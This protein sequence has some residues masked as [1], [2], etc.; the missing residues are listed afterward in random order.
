MK[1][2]VIQKKRIGDVL[3][4]TLLLEALREKFPKAELH[5]LIYPESV[6]VVKNNPFVDKMVVLDKVIK[7]NTFKFLSFLWKLR[8]EKYQ[9]VVDAYGKPNS[10]LMGW[11][12]GAKMT[13]AFDKK[14]SRLLYSHPV[15]RDESFL[16]HASYAI[17]HRMQLLKPLG[18]DFKIIEPKIVLE[19]SEIEEAKT[20]LSA[21]TINLS[22]PIVIIS[23]IG[24]NPLKT[25][26][27]E[28]MAKVIDTIA[29]NSDVQIL[30]NYIPFQKNL[31]LELFNKCKIES[32]SKIFFEVYENDLRKFLGILS[33][34]KALI[35]NEGGSVH[36]A[37]ALKVPTFTIFAPGVQKN[38]WNVFENETTNISVHINDYLPNATLNQ[39]ELAQK[40]EPIL[41]EASLAKFC[42]LN[43]KL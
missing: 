14:Y 1:I 5:Y 15:I 20:Y 11:F 24:S 12:T 33:Q 21:H 8:R 27:L 32:Q 39:F 3:T 34:C 7:K 22:N 31:A 13:I 25:Y 38:R 36:M 26:P 30:L 29:Q 35:G 19:N 42:A 37:K 4:S 28:Y 17:V 41:F 6:A 2:L 10:I 18:I 40:F 16:Q 23:A 9:I 43:F